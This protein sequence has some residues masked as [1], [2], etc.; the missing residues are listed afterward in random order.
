[1]NTAPGG[2]PSVSSGGVVGDVAW[3]FVSPQS[4]LEPGH[5]RNDMNI[6]FPDVKLPQTNWTELNTKKHGNLQITNYWVTA[7]GYYAI[8]NDINGQNNKNNIPVGVDIDIA[9]TNV[10][11][12]LPTGIKYSTGNILTIESNCDLTLYVGNSVIL[13]GQGSVNNAGDYAPA[14]YMYGLPTCTSINLGGAMAITAAVYAPEAT[15]NAGGGGNNT[16]DA[17]GSFIVHDIVFGG[18]M[19]FH[20]DEQLLKVGPNIGYVPAVWQE[21]R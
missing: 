20:F 5:T 7:S 9:A 18:H 19:N 16:Y 10:F 14:F 4:G 3:T 6:V 15:L 11:L 8:T 12:Y 2:T 1:V 13:S 21:V 17:V